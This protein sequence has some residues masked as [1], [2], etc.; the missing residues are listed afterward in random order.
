M[1]RTG[2]HTIDNPSRQRANEPVISRKTAIIPIAANGTPGTAE[3]LLAEFASSYNTTYTADTWHLVAGALDGFLLVPGPTATAMYV[4]DSDGI[5][6]GGGTGK[7]IP[8]PAAGGLYFPLA[9]WPE[10]TLMY[11]VDAE[12]YAMLF[13]NAL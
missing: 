1:V 13:F 7:G 10:S 6:A 4:R 12:S 9:N 11:E 8:V 2:T 5:G 3:D